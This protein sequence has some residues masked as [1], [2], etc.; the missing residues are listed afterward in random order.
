MIAGI[1]TLGGLL[2]AGVAIAGEHGP[3]AGVRV[4]I[5][6]ATAVTLLA[7]LLAGSHLRGG[8]ARLTRRF[9][10]PIPIAGAAPLPRTVIEVAALS[11]A[12]WLLDLA[13]L[14]LSLR[15]VGADVPLTGLLLVYALSQV[16]QSLPLLPGGGGTVEAS[17][18]LGFAAFG[19]T[20]GS[21]IAGVLLYRLISTWGLVPLGWTAIALDSRHTFINKLPR[22]KHIHA[23][24]S[25]AR[26]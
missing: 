21:V 12:N 17:L 8:L 18:S 25:H 14:Y 1:A 16:V 6:A 24:R 10:P 7:T 22:P 4:P 11:V 20:T 23:S 15:A 19:H 5:L 9:A 2:V 3:L 26:A 13:T